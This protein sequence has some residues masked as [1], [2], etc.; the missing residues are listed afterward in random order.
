MVSPRTWPLSLALL[1]G[2]ACTDRPT[3]VPSIA[4]DPVSV[5]TVPVPAS[6]SA[7]GAPAVST[8]SPEPNVAPAHDDSP[9]TVERVDVPGDLP[10]SFV[11]SADG[12]PPRAVF[13]AGV[14]SS[15]YAYL[16]AFPEAARRAGGIVTIEGDEPCPGAPGFRTLS[17]DAEKQRHRIE[18]ALVAADPRGDPRAALTVIGSSRGASVL[19]R[20]AE[21]DPSRYARVVIIASPTD[22]IAKRY[23]SVH[24]VVT[25][26]CS[27]DVPFRMK[28]A[29]R[30][31]AALGVP[32][33]YVEM[34]GCTHGNLTDAETTFSGV[35]EWLASN[36]R[37]GSAE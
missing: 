12:N 20:L 26:S 10:A 15:A 32:A 34:A 5:A 17:G 35:F 21:K 27:R 19:E 6:A 2:G 11:R 37:G 23:V 9:A 31:I 13:L 30:E 24:A 33:R 16:L 1:L 36:A 22:P 25:M 3:P 14:C 8:T 4:P 29:A 28:T 7:R 18:A